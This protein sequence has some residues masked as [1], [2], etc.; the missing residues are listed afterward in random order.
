MAVGLA[1]FL[2]H[3]G[4]PH[5]RATALVHRAVKLAEELQSDVRTI[6]AMSGLWIMGLSVADY[7]AMDRAS[8]NVRHL[9]ERSGDRP[10]QVFSIMME[11]MACTFSGEL[12]RAKQLAQRAFDE[13]SPRLVLSYHAPLTMDQNRSFPIPK[14]RALFLQGELEAGLALSREV[15]DLASKIDHQVPLMITLGLLACPVAFWSGDWQLAAEL[16]DRFKQHIDRHSAAY[17]R[18]QWVRGYELALRLCEQD[19]VETSPTTDFDML[20]HDHLCTIHEDFVTP[21]ALARANAGKA[22]WAAPEIF[23]AQGNRLLRNGAACEGESLLRKAVEV[24]QHQG[25]RFWELRAATDLA[26]YLQTVDR[27][28][29]AVQTLESI[30]AAFADGPQLRD[31]QKHNRCGPHS[32]S[33]QFENSADAVARLN[34]T[35]R[36]DS[37]AFAYS[38]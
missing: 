15:T 23:R 10:G 35:Q 29:E 2:F 3:A 36:R 14:P 7:A 33:L 37:G 38:L 32:T 16:I 30:F 4:G 24:A 8:N 34:K 25:A 11:A 31:V 22:G 12:E 19:A 1:N 28:A 27:R 17:Y 5:D 6:E 26:S 18:R 20:L 13:P 9:A 21:G